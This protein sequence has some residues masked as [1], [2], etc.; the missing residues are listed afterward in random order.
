M[1]PHASKIQLH[2]VTITPAVHSLLRRGAPHHAY[3]LFGTKD[4][5]ACC[6]GAVPVSAKDDEELLS[7]QC[8][9]IEKMAPNGLHVL[10]FASRKAIRTPPTPLGTIPISDSGELPPQLSVAPPN[11]VSCTTSPVT[12]VSTHVLPPSKD[13]VGAV[14]L[15]VSELEERM[16]TL[17]PASFSASSKP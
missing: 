12:F 4:R 14:E 8:A 10:G 17:S 2:E 7:D 11:L 5:P 9:E 6:C 15:A 1:A 3:V 16:R 13:V